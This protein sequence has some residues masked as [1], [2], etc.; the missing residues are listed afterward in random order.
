M[1]KLSVNLRTYMSAHKMRQIDL[2]RQLG[3]T[4]SNVSQWL[5]DKHEPSGE[6]LTKM[7]QIFHVTAEQL[8]GEAEYLQG[9]RAGEGYSHITRLAWL[10][11]LRARWQRPEQPMELE[12]LKLAVRACWRDEAK[13]VISWLNEKHS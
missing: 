10:D 1:S 4:Q 6:M 12:L 3:A 9:K 13:D 8:R 11:R 5:S 2:A 7:T